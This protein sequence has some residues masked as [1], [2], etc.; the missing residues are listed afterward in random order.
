MASATIYQHEL[1]ITMNTGVANGITLVRYG[2]RLTSL[3]RNRNMPPKERNFVAIGTPDI[4]KATELAKAL[5]GEVD[6]IK[7]GKELFTAQGQNSL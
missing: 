4:N 2:F 6:G 5:S 1:L 3:T 7:I